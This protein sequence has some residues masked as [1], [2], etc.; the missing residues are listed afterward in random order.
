MQF[1]ALSSPKVEESASM[2]LK[3]LKVASAKPVG[4][5]RWTKHAVLSVGDTFPTACLLDKRRAALLVDD[6]DAARD[7]EEKDDVDDDDD[8]DYAGT[9]ADEEADDDGG[10]PNAIWIVR[11]NVQVQGC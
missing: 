7:E 4:G 2:T 9:D 6:A 5:C 11:L 8:D 3:S 1:D 10:D